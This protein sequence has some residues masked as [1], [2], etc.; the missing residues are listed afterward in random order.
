M[1]F[2]K[3]FAEIV[4]A[5]GKKDGFEKQISDFIWTEQL[6]SDGDIVLAAVSGGADSVAMLLALD[7]LRRSGTPS[8]LLSVCCV[9]HG[10]RGEESR[11]DAEFVKKLCKRLSCSCTVVSVDAPGYAKKSG[12]SLEEA[13]RDL[14]RKALCDTARSL[15][16]PDPCV[17]PVRIALAH[18][19]EDSAETVL[20]QMVRGSG[21]AGLRGLAPQGMWDGVVLIRPLL[22]QKRG[23]IEAY[24]EEKGQTF[25][26]DSTNEDE[27]ISRNF[28]RRQVMPLLEQENPKAQD[29][30]ASAGRKIAELYDIF[31]GQMDRMLDEGGAD[32]CSFPVALLDGTSGAMGRELLH[33][34]L[35]R[36]LPS[37]RDLSEAHIEAVFDL[38]RRQ[39]GKR[40]MLPAG[41]EA[42]RSYERIFLTTPVAPQEC[43]EPVEIDLA[44]LERTKELKVCFGT[45][46]FTLRLLEDADPRNFPT[47]TYAKWFD[48]DKIKKGMCIRTYRPGDRLS[49]DRAGRHVPVNRFFINERI[50]GKQRGMP[51]LCDGSDVLWIVGYRI[52]FD[53]MVFSQTRRIL[54]VEVG[55]PFFQNE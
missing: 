44:Q 5:M 37:A 40:I 10:I 31:C 23:Q 27:N 14:R 6:I 48:Y 13:A 1:F 33:R 51:L 30:I 29:H 22:Q 24:L 41:C 15:N 3:G 47:G 43:C 42:E 25:R 20:F 11:A 4:Y 46:D 17:R 21:A 28:L 50:P 16:D 18:H 19:L 45:A 39:S 26:S 54:S 7:A 38:G 35:Y 2:Y 36:A 9:E 52:G 8:F 49:F 53:Y 32:D 12:R 34:W 55:G